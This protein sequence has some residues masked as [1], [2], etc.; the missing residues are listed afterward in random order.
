MQRRSHIMKWFVGILS[1]PLKHF[2]FRVCV[3]EPWSPRKLLRL[4]SMNSVSREHWHQLSTII[5]TCSRQWDK[6]NY[7]WLKCPLSLFGSAHFLY[8]NNSIPESVWGSAYKV[9][10]FF[11]LF[12]CFYECDLRWWV[13]LGIGFLGEWLKERGVQHVLVWYG[14]FVV[15]MYSISY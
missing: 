15:I 11:V 5:E 10:S 9:E 12:L 13:V 4:S 3:T 1:E 8:V 14:S 2:L 6:E 7:N